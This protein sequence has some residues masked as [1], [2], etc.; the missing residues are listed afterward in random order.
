[1]QMI[2]S[3]L[4][5]LIEKCDDHSE[6]YVHIRRLENYEQYYVSRISSNPIHLNL[7]VIRH[8]ESTIEIHELKNAI[9]RYND[10]TSFGFMIFDPRFE[11]QEG[12]NFDRA[13]LDRD[14]NLHLYAYIQPRPVL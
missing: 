7:D 10:N 5:G 8:Q 1:M 3:D 2:I 9:R 11:N 12:G 4:K 6:V 14:G 13:E